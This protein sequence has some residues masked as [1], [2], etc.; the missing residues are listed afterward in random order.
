MPDARPALSDRLES[1]IPGV[2]VAGDLAGAPVVKL[3]MEQGVAVAR[4]IAS[5]HEHSSR[6]PD[7][8]DLLVVG[9]GAAGLSAALEAQ[10]LGLRVVV[11]E[12]GRIGS[13]VADLPEGKWIYAE[14]SDRPVTGPLPLIETTKDELVRLW[15]D[16]VRESR[17][18]VR[19]GVSLQ[20]V[21]RSGEGF[22]VTTSSG[23]FQA[24][25]IVLAI[26]K[27]GNPRRLGTEGESSPRVHHKL[28]SP[29]SYRGKQILVI[30]GGNSAVEAAVA[31]ASNNSVTLIHRGSGLARVSKRNLEALSQSAVT[32][33]LNTEV[34]GFD[35]PECKLSTGERLAFDEAFVLI[36]SEAPKTFLKSLG[37]RLENEWT[38]SPVIASISTLAVFFG[39]AFF[40]GEYTQ[41]GLV[42]LAVAVLGLSFLIGRGSLGDRFCLLGL[43]LSIAYTIY[44]AK[45]AP[46][47]EFWP[48]RGWGFAMLSFFGRP[49]S[50]WYTILYTGLMTYFGI[51][52]MRRWGF[53]RKD[54]FQIW[55]YVSLLSFQ[56]IF[57]FLIPEVLFRWA[58]KYQWV[59]EKLATDQSF[60]DA[61][62][63][64][65][66]LIYAW[67]LFFYTFFGSPH[68]VWIV[69]GAVL[70]F[71]IIPILVLLHGKRYCSWICGCG[72]LAET[73]GDRWRHLSPKGDRSIAWE[74][75]NIVVLVAA[76]LITVGI[77]FRDALALFNK[78]A[79]VALVW[80][81]LIADTWLVGIVPITL[82][83]F[84][85]GK[86]WCRYWCPL[87]KMMEIF[88]KAFTRFK[89]SRFAIHSNDKCISCG[90]CTRNCQV[91]I[92]VMKFA[93]NQAE[94]SNA[95]SSC[96]GCGICVTV[97]PMNVLSFATPSAN[98][99]KDLVQ[100]QRAA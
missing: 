69:W 93:Q 53:A 62:W 13:T 52:A 63:R 64:S 66:G 89:V 88:S 2:Y 73:V 25:R 21:Q 20:S 54:R 68:Q 82:Y 60:A 87:A 31:L 19:V 49:W 97:C 16:K 44:G 41:T 3:A 81:R 27:G 83:P 14:P 76:V 39:L 10:K 35:G 75:M 95:N 47:H 86:V 9:A 91:G 8:A 4:H 85:G 15:E 17:L 36:G 46:G 50:F 90:E 59:G 96:I 24:R 58:V 99:H 100:I 78:P 48:F 28:H 67:P 79:D 30:G 5:L 26:G 57:F 23:T 61:G 11:I 1:S 55:R 92:D 33:R 71:I 65:Y 6:N 80:Y 37:L 18:D 32:Q 29:K 34:V 77:V 56:W 42:G 40:A 45:Q 84:M 7:V 72:G 38:G 12:K 94:L 70:S 51:A 43:C 74:R 98:T 22:A